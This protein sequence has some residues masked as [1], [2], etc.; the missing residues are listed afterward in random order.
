MMR[1]P[2]SQRGKTSAHV[3]CLFVDIGGVLLTNGWDHRARRR[4]AQH[5]ALQIAE[6]QDRHH[7]IFATY[8]I[9]KITLDAYLDQVV[10]HCKRPFTRAQFRTFMFAQSLPFPEMLQLVARL[11]AKHSLKV[12]AVSNEGRELN[13]YRIRKFQLTEIIDGFI[14]S[15][16]VG[17]SKPDAELFRYALD[18]AQ[19][20][21][22]QVVY[23]ENTAM[24]VQIA[25]S[26]GIRS[27]LH[28]EIES[29]R[30]QL[31]AYGLRDDDRI[32][33]ETR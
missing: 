31:A 30:A 13:A 16:F 11:K 1:S 2:G 15:C 27:V 28:T 20:M 12:I 6:M 32:S 4:A 7:L 17:I 3:T 25:E 19:V 5:F 8:E 14:S 22:S 9:G 33:H 21:P 18:F 24:F 10:F 23:L 26:L 29:T